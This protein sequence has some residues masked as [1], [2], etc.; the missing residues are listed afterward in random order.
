M[1]TKYMILYIYI[2]VYGIS[3]TIFCLNHITCDAIGH[4]KV[5]PYIHTA[6]ASNLTFL[7]YACKKKE[8]FKGCLHR[9]PCN[10]HLSSVQHWRLSTTSTGWR[11][12]VSRNLPG[13]R[14]YDDISFIHHPFSTNSAAPSIFRWGQHL[15]FLHRWNCCTGFGST[16]WSQLR[17]A[18]QTQN[19]QKPPEV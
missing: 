17:G 12:L 14:D 8:S 7:L 2:Y 18:N 16:S 1:L 9:N 13:S 4:W 3:Y 5:G 6:C 11:M 15:K 10:K 19:H